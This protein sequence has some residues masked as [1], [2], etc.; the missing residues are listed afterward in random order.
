M[1]LFDTLLKNIQ[2]K[3]LQTDF[4]QNYFVERE[5]GKGAFATVKQVTKKSDGKKFAVKIIDKKRAKGQENS[6][7]DEIEVLRQLS[8]RH[9]ISMVD[10]YESSKF[11]YLVM[12]LATGGELFERILAKGFYTEQD[13]AS[14]IK[15]LL[16]ALVYIHNE[17][18]IVH[19]DLKPE[20][21]LF[22]DKSEE[23]DLLL[24]DFGLARVIQHNEFLSTSCGTPHCNFIVDIDVAPEILRESGH[25]KPVDM[26]STGVITFVLICGYTPFWGGEANSM[27][28]LY[29]SILSGKFEYEAEYWGMVTFS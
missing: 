25:G 10:L 13:A 6:I 9:I 24:T 4:E 19:R 18:G 1:G 5:L 21:L 20:N 7:Q 11:Y 15:Q 23:S 12:E 8:H 26:W 3:P 22:R 17:V 16:S 27:P 2:R 29:D 28:L 14:L